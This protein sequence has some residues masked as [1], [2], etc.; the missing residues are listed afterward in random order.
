MRIIS[1]FKDYYDYLSDPKDNDHIFLRHKRD[2]TCT[3]A[4]VDAVVR[5]KIADGFFRSSPFMFCPIVG[6]SAEIKYGVFFFCG[7]IYPYCEVI[8]TLHGHKNVNTFFDIQVGFDCYFGLPVF[9]PLVT[10]TRTLL[11]EKFFTKSSQL[12]Y[13]ERIVNSFKRLNDKKEALNN[14]SMFFKLPYFIVL[15]DSTVIDCPILSE[16]SF[17]NIMSSEQAYQNI[18]MYL[19]NSLFNNELTRIPVG[20]DKTLAKS[21]GFDKYSFRKE[22]TKHKGRIK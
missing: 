11:Q 3:T 10:D 9:S 12:R 1:S 13:S 21:K 14:I 7:N 22:S 2:Y 8:Y 17:Q 4:I 20:D 6:E 19:S 16:I 5:N 15:F 18:D